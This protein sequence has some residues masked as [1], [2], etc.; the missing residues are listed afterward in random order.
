V[1]ACDGIGF[2]VS[3]ISPVSGQNIEAGV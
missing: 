1:A 3:T 2:N